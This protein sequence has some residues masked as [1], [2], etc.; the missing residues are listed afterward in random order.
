[1]NAALR[2]DLAAALDRADRGDRAAAELRLQLAASQQ[3]IEELSA[4]V[5]PELRE[6]NAREQQR[7]RQIRRLIA[8]SERADVAIARVL[9]DPLR[10]LI[11]H[12]SNTGLP[13]L[14]AEFM[15]S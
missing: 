13:F 15:V 8:G 10:I 9:E 4:D 5:H 3:R 2:S 6:A 11:T 7:E 12:A 1:M 14:T